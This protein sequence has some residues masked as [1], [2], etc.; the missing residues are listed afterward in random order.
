M[1]NAGIW[2][3]ILEQTNSL[4]YCQKNNEKMAKVQGFPGCRKLGGSNLIPRTP[5][6]LSIGN[7]HSF[8]TESVKLDPTDESVSM[9]GGSS[10]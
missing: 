3:R 9:V 2:W 4:R 7:E 6:F 1:N 8:P 5:R 10:M